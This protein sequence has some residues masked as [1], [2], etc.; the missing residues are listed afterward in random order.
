MLGQKHIDSI[1]TLVGRFKKQLRENGKS[2]ATVT[3]YASDLQEF[4][5]YLEAIKL[6][7]SQ[8]DAFILDAYR[9]TLL[10][11]RSHRENSVR[12]KIIAVRA[13]L[14]IQFDRESSAVSSVSESF[15]IPKRDE[16]L[17]NIFDKISLHQLIQACDS[18]SKLK[19]LR[20]KA[21]VMLIAAQGLKSS[22]LISLKISDVMLQAP[23]YSINITGTRARVVDLDIKTAEI[24][25]KYLDVLLPFITKI[26]LKKENIHLFIAF[27]N[28]DLESILPKMSRH[29][30]KFTLYEIGSRIAQPKLSS[31]SLRNFYIAN[32]LLEGTSIQ[33]LM[34]TLGLKRPGLIA[35]HART[36]KMHLT[37]QQENSL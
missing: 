24:L 29:G 28:R 25:K 32:Q 1:E 3:A 23:Y 35:K 10:G 5:H 30:M 19:S 2:Q 4:L 27:K 14:R 15:P 13:F 22:E 21:L 11:E 33:R 8:I 12:R 37:Q 34:E 36:V 18:K 17:N 7:V 31:E 16:S 20:D 6:E 9:K 26:G